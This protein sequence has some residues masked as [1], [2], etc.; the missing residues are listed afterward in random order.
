MEA[1]ASALLG[2]L[3]QQHPALTPRKT[4]LIGVSGGRDS[5]ALLHHLHMRGWKKLVVVHL[6]HSLRGRE[7]GQD[8]AFVRRLAERWGFRY[9][10]LKRDISA[11][12][13][14]KRLSLETAARYER[15][16]LFAKLCRQFRTKFVFLA[17][18]AEDNAE[19][20]VGNL[21]RGASLRGAAGIKPVSPTQDG[22]SK[23]RPLL[24]VRRAEIDAYIAQY[25]LPFRED[26]S[27]ASAVHRRNRLRHEVLPLLSQVF[28]RD[29][30][31]LVTRFAKLAERDD[32]C[33]SQQARAFCEAQRFLAEPGQLS[34]TAPFLELHEALQSR[35]LYQWLQSEQV[36]LIG[37]REIEGALSL[38]R[39]PSPASI[40]LPGGAQLR[41]ARGVL[42][43]RW[44]AHPPKRG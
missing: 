20:I 40:N 10:G 35:I 5:V 44:S 41:Y 2:S 37:Q 8:A 21:F 38:L 11:L 16:A 1:K 34:V 19:T 39:S 18:H 14:E 42:C 30:T 22:W 26:S 17:H 29:V 12:A 24:E 6:N 23:V 13:K 27:N 31:P 36:P 28:H 9:E 15:D 3:L 25:Q 43:V 4:C 33:L 7:S 32:D